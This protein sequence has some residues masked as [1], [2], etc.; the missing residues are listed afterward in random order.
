[1]RSTMQDV[2]LSLRRI[3]EH[4]S[5]VHAEARVT[6]WRPDSGGPRT[7][8]F[9]ETG[10]NAARLAHGLAAGLG[11][12]PGEPVA[13]LMF[14]NT[15]HLECYLAI[16]AM[17]AVLHTLN[18]RLPAD[19]L[20]W[21]VNHVADRVVVADAATAPLLAGILPQLKTVEHVVV[22]ADAVPEPLTAA[23]AAIAAGETGPTLE[24]IRS[25]APHLHTYASLTD[26]QRIDYP[27]PDVDE[28]DAAAICYSSGTTGLPRG[29]VYSHRS[30]YLHSLQCMAVESLALSWNDT[31][32]PVV[33]MFHVNA[34]GVPHAAFLAGT[35]LL[36]PDR[37]LQAVPLAEM[38]TAERPTFAAAVPTIWAG[39]LAELDAHGAERGYDVSSLRTVVIGG[40]ACPE[41]L[42]TGFQRYGAHVV[43]AWGMTETS[44]LGAVNRPPSRPLPDVDPELYRSSQGRVPGSVQARIVGPDGEV[45]PHDG[46]SAG[47]LE[48]R[49]PWITG[50]YYEGAHGVPETAADDRFDD[51]WLRTGDV[52]TLTPDGYLTLTD[53]AKDVIKSGGEWISS[54]ALENRLM[55]HPEVAEAAVIAVPDEK[56]GER[57][58]AAVVPAGEAVDFAG[59]R[60]YLA[61]GVA[62]WQV[63]EW[64]TEID[65]VPKTSVGKFD[66]KVLRGRYAH[67]ELD[68]REI[69]E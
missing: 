23:A 37:H 17:G 49:G 34:W 51:G 29:V 64:W 25:A 1:M 10:A 9:A 4:G 68:V 41:G 45:L 30:V 31:A 47:E 2:P 40:S 19:Q 54:V 48:V 57:P 44:P 12:R 66:K 67:G 50:A 35:S 16:P 22:V 5:T 32:L 7:Q 65:E 26:G 24:G 58:L 52:G 13:T 39:L 6:T 20:V 53:R 42:M 11:V 61:E 62:R 15:E 56:W 14:N 27:W 8:T 55:G 28:R 69:R 59:L 63:P 60:A 33:P 36:M 43:H 3:L 21:I 46:A 18:L 38:I